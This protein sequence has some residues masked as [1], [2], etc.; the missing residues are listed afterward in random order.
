VW[1]RFC[2]RFL[3][4][5]FLTVTRIFINDANSVLL[6][7][8]II[9]KDRKFNLYLFMFVFFMVPFTEPFR[10]TTYILVVIRSFFWCHSNRRS[11][12]LWPIEI[13][14]H[15]RHLLS[16]ITFIECACKLRACAAWGVF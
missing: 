8:A 13:W 11:N 7:M 5:P 4:R 15:S 2:D 9:L 10:H 12:S 16:K 1:Q 3:K 14:L 6:R